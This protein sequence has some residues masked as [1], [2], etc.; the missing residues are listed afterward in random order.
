ME[1]QY[2]FERLLNTQL[3]KDWFLGAKQSFYENNKN[4]SKYGLKL[5][6]HLDWVTLDQIVSPSKQSI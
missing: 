6:R 5:S 1:H 2:R 3:V 4:H